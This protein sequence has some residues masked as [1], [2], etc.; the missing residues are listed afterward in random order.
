MIADNP[1]TSQIMELSSGRKLAFAEYGSSTGIPVFYFHGNF[2][3][4]L[5][6]TLGNEELLE[7]LGIRFICPDRPGM[8]LSDY[9]NKRSILDWPDDIQE[10]VKYLKLEKY[11]L[12]GGSG[13]GPY[14]LACAYKLP[15]T[16]SLGCAI[17]SGLGPYEMSKKGMNSR[18]KNLLF[19]ARYFPWTFKFLTWLTM[20]RK[21]K[22]KN[23]EWW[24]KNYQKLQKQLPDPD[25]IIMQNSTTRDCMTYKTIEAFRQ[26]SKGPSH[27]FKL[28]ARPWGFKLEDIPI[29]TKVLIFHGELDT[30]VPISMAKTMNS[31]IPN[32]DSK[33]YPDEGHLSLY[34][35]NLEEI[36]TSLLAD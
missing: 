27:D 3:S 9:Q 23:V 35:N 6:A 4:R 15:Q 26:G 20:G 8:G 7:S 31:L 21:I 32:C 22:S 13:G 11:A 10:L 30:S 2:G 28:Y 14:A 5:E 33:Y 17:V 12:I 25:R 34:I 36:L 24:E 19:V 16:E 18:S 29:E 1:Q